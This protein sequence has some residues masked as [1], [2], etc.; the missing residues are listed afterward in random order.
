MI[1]CTRDWG[2]IGEHAYWRRLLDRM[3]VGRPELPNSPIYA[4]EDSQETMPAPEWGS[5]LSIVYGSLNPVLVSDLDQ[6]V[7]KELMAENRGL[8]LL[9]FKTGSEYSSVTTTRGECSDEQ[10]TPAVSTPLADADDRLSDIASAIPPVD[11]EVLTL[12]HSAFLAQ[13]LTDEVHLGESTH[14]GPL[15]HAIFS[16]QATN[17]PT[18]KV[19]GT[20]PSPN[21]MPVSWYD[22]QDLHKVLWAKAEGIDER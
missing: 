18:D 8:T 12:K 16:M 7:R 1:L 17:G 4:P 9:D 2:T 3:T 22:V 10:E 15:D 20:K 6:V 21:N 11:P 14:G 13:L 5:F 19:L